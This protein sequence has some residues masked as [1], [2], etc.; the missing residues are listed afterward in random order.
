MKQQF[1]VYFISKVLTGSKRYYSE[2]EKICYTVV[3]SARKLHH[4]FKAHTIR[5]LTK[6]P[7]ND[8][9][10]NK[11]SSGRISKWAMELSEHVVDFKKISA[12]K[13]Q[14]ITNFVAEWMKPGFCNEGIVLELP[15]LIYCAGAWG[16]VKA[17]VAVVLISPSGIKL[18]YTARL[19]FTN[20][21]D[22][23]TNNIAKYKAILLGLH[24]LRAIGV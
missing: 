10:D 16:S 7:L 2:I 9:F 5:V 6:K 18:C 12:I 17:R 4:Y 24:K 21:A 19:Q 1:S 14:I 22:K 11:D 13:S 8:I 3:M 15:W 23:C 20:E